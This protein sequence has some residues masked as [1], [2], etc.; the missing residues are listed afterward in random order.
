[1]ATK[2]AEDT[3]LKDAKVGLHK[4]IQENLA[5]KKVRVC[6][7]CRSANCYLRPTL[8]NKHKIQKRYGPGCTGKQI[9]FDELRLKKPQQLSPILLPPI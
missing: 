5:Q 4:D 1:M 6:W 2:L 3:S 9:T 7:C 8:S